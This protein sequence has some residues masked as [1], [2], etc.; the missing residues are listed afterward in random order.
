MSK[1]MTSTETHLVWE[2]FFSDPSIDLIRYELQANLDGKQFQNR[3]FLLATPAPGD[4]GSLMGEGYRDEE[5]EVGQTKWYR[6]RAVSSSGNSS[7]SNVV[8]VAT[9]KG[10][11]GPPANVRA[12]PSGS[13]TINLYWRLPSN[14][15]GSPVQRYQIEATSQ[16]ALPEIKTIERFEEEGECDFVLIPSLSTATVGTS[17]VVLIKTKIG[18]IGSGRPTRQA[19]APSQTGCRRPR[20]SPPWMG[21]P[22]CAKPHRRG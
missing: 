14:E 7:W 2:Q 10:P 5:V 3:W 8:E 18:I 16:D 15:G 6:I 1:S 19:G 4:R 13:R 9:R 17:M 20:N 21:A 12:E 11:P 22:A